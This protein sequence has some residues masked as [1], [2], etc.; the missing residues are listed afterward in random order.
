MSR[1]ERLYQLERPPFSS[2]EFHAKFTNLVGPVTLFEAEDDADVGNDN[3]EIERPLTPIEEAVKCPPL[4]F[5][6]F[7]KLVRPRLLPREGIAGLSAD[8]QQ[9]LIEI[10]MSELNDI[11]REV[12]R[13][14]PD[15]F[16]TS[17]QNKEL[18]RRLTI[19]IVVITQGLFAKYLNKAV[20]LNHR[21]VFSGPANLSRLKTQ[22]ASEASKCL[23]VS[24]LKR[25]LAADMKHPGDASTV[26]SKFSFSK[27]F[28]VG[29]SSKQQ[30]T[31][32]VTRQEEDKKGNKNLSRAEKQ[33]LWLD[34]ELTDLQKKMPHAELPASLHLTL[35][36][37]VTLT[38]K[39][40]QDFDDSFS[41][42]E[43]PVAGNMDEARYSYLLQR[44][45]SL[46][47]LF[48]RDVVLEELGVLREDLQEHVKKRTQSETKLTDDVRFQECIVNE[49]TGEKSR[50]EDNAS[51]DLMRLLMPS[52]HAKTRESLQDEEENDDLPPLLQALARHS[53][54][55]KE[56]DQRREGR[57]VRDDE[58]K[59]KD[60]DDDAASVTSKIHSTEAS[61]VAND[62]TILDENI[63]E[64]TGEEHPQPAVVSL[65]LPD[66]SVVRTSDV[67]VSNRVNKESLTLRKY[68]TVYNDLTGEID[69]PT[70]K[71]LDRN[72]FIGE[73][74]REVY[75]EITKTIGTNHLLFD[76]DAYVEKSP[77]TVDVTLSTS[78]TSLR[79]PR[80]ER[81][82]NKKLKTGSPPPWGH[83]TAENWR[84]SPKFG[85]LGREDIL[86]AKLKKGE[87]GTQGSK[88]YNSWLAWWRS[89][90]TTDDFLKYLSTQENDFMSLLFHLYDSDNEDDNDEDGDEARPDTVQMALMRER[91]KKLAELRSLKSDFKPGV[92]NVNAVLLG[93]LGKE[94]EV[95]DNELLAN[96]NDAS[97]TTSSRLALGVA[98]GLPASA[99]TSLYSLASV[100]TRASQSQR[101]ERSQGASLAAGEKIQASR[102]VSALAE[103]ASTSEIGSLSAQDR[104]ERIWTL[105]YMPDAQRLDMA[106][107]YSAEPYSTKLLDSLVVWE[108]ATEAV[109]ERE[110]LMTKIEDFER[111][112]SDP[113]RFFVKGTTGSSVERIRESRTRESFNKRMSKIESHVRRA[114][115]DV[116]LQFDDTVT[117]QGRPYLEKMNRDRTE[118]FY[119]L[120]Q[121]RRQQ[122]LDR[123]LVKMR[124]LTL[125]TPDLPPIQAHAIL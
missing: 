123:E 14:P 108:I 5:N 48:S 118:M 102:S 71:W 100:E 85:G 66:K 1:T 75:E 29:A 56:K 65:R 24:S 89:T 111:T 10:L 68:S 90:I 4:S 94:P 39:A 40:Q 6:A 76:E 64:F 25:D 21:G 53:T 36:M 23:N 11:W 34:H 38:K 70:V 9:Q 43:I 83:D 55:K 22:L 73:E 51:Q 32:L 60:E 37:N 72:L 28:Q 109:L 57:L 17:Q 107:K 97:S 27:P 30:Y 44:Y 20:K 115:R 79:K 91:E 74:I 84:N 33:K 95:D 86:Q 69:A 92:W 41:D 58:S 15:P 103:M 12:H 59:S 87:D 104:L 62:P 88:S 105:L 49:T 54:T 98:A 31:A 116:R 13:G 80:I 119:W 18:Q 46:P 121:E 52:R 35:P 99:G 124:E 101:L 19:E 93:G 114:V 78:S 106:I 8:D 96:I 77:T 110:S 63:T 82:I 45:A 47:D 67:R 81:I 42:E 122:A 125:K 61:S 117:F 16:L 113:N 50:S 26:S 7:A 2:R 112:A 3:P 120:Q